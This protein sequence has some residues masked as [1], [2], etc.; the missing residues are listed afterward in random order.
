MDDDDIYGKNYLYDMMLH[1]R[2]VDADVFGKAPNFITF[3][4]SKKTYIR[5]MASQALSVIDP[6]Q[7]DIGF[8]PRISG[9]TMAG[10]T[11]F[12]RLSRYPD[13]SYGAADSFFLLN[14]KFDNAV[15]AIVDNLNAVAVRRQDIS[16]HTWRQSEEKIASNAQYLCKGVGDVLV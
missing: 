13:H 8:N 3:E 11:S 1:Q 12:L 10:K 14:A 7:F 6:N 15:V 5:S 9:Y 2:A 16:S 4:E